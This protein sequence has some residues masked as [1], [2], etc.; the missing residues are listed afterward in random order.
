MPSEESSAGIEQSDGP[1]CIV[2][3]EPSENLSWAQFTD[4]SEGLI[5]EPCEERILDENGVSPL[6]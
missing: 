1:L 5:C 6:E 2:C 4:G 3:E